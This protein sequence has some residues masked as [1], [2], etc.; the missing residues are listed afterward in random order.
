MHKKGYTLIELILVI[1]II[2]ILATISLPIY[3][4]SLAH[5]RHSMALRMIV[6]DIRMIQQQ[7]ITERRSY[8]LIFNTTETTGHL[9][10]YWLGRE[11]SIVESRQLPE[12]N[13]VIETN[14]ENDTLS[15]NPSGEPSRGGG[16][17]TIGDSLGNKSYV[18]VTPATG[19]VKISDKLS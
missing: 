1:S 11:E 3:R 2:G 8:K 13:R 7:S 5:Y 18:I 10:D 17:I 12:G 19:K 6:S 4:T 15:F 16:H 14:F 9:T